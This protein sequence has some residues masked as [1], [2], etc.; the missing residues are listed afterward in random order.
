MGTTTERTP[1]GRR[2]VVSR[3]VAADRERVWTVL[4]DTER[5][6]DWGPSVTAVDA[7]TRIV[8]AGS[9]GRV[10][11]P[12]GVWLPFEITSCAGYRWTWR[13]AR[14]PA[15][16]HRVEAAGDGCTVAFEL[17]LY[18]TPYAPVCVR[19]LDRVEKLATRD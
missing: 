16:G 6:P 13:V 1:S 19:A 7:D 12:G 2:L 8:E 11:L 4:T 9:T 5:W 18:A 3:D 14:I 17:P 15:T 10:R